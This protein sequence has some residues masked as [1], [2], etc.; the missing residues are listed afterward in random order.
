MLPADAV[1]D[2]PP[3]IDILVLAAPPPA[4]PET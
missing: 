1:D 2:P 4:T 3:N